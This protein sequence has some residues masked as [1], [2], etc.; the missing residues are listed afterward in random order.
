M[1]DIE[2]LMTNLDNMDKTFNI[3][4]T[5]IENVMGEVKKTQGK[6]NNQVE[7]KMSIDNRFN[8]IQNLLNKEKTYF[9]N[10]AKLS[11]VIHAEFQQLDTQMANVFKGTEQVPTAKSTLQSVITNNYTSK[12]GNMGGFMLAAGSA[13]AI[14][15]LSKWNTKMN[16]LN[17]NVQTTTSTVKKNTETAN[18]EAKKAATKPTD[19]VAFDK[20]K[21]KSVS[22][23]GKDYSNYTILAGASLE[24]LYCQKNYSAKGF[25]SKG[26]YSTADAI[27]QSIADQKKYNPTSTW[28]TKQQLSS[29]LRT[30]KISG[31][32]SYT[33]AQ[34]LSE[35][36]KQLQ[37]GNPVMLRVET[38]TGASG[39]SVVAVGIRNGANPNKLTDKDILIVDPADGKIKTLADRYK[40]VGNSALKVNSGY[41][42]RIPK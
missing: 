39:H 16:A 20:N 11:D 29:G 26:C 41:S 5:Q 30:K 8:R 28:D 36:Y 31:S 33:E 12:Y 9:E 3:L 13:W 2:L 14:S 15:E 35:T 23:K 27:M 24:Y 7:A 21:Y 34:M 18:A 1:A 19:L 38:S 25:A 40:A 10:F 32:K 42:M 4:A 37:K 22:Y 6:L 17:K